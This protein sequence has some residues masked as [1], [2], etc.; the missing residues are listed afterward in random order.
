[1]TPAREAIYLPFLCLTVV[2]LGGVRMGAPAVLLPPTLFMLVLG[3]MLIGV[4]IQ[5]GALAPERVLNE[6]R[7]ALENVNGF[8]L[9]VAL[10]LACSQTFAILTPVSGLPRVIVSVYFLIL[11]LNTFAAKPD[12]VR[13]LR[14]LGVT[15]GTAFVLN[16]VVLDALSDPK[17]GW[18]T[19][20]FQVLLEGIT[21]GALIQPVHHP[22]TGYI[23]F[24]TLVLF[25]VILSL[26]PARRSLSARRGEIPPASDDDRPRLTHH[27]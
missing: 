24:F 20:L 1:M 9:L 2:L 10:F 11:M 21:L 8:V 18:L 4:L 15:F 22:A 26:L 7:S 12:R 19:R 27:T 6:S 14:S 16:F 13:V 5:S 25:L 3:F 23:A 17:G